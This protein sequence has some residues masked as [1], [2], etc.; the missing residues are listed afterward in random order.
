[1][2][3]R[4][5]TRILT[6]LVAVAQ[7]TSVTDPTLAAG[8]A[9]ASKSSKS[10]KTKSSKQTNASE[11]T[12]ENCKKA[13]VYSAKF[14]GVTLLVIQNGKVIYQK[15][16]NG[17]SADKAYEL[18]SGTK[19][20]SG[21]AALAAKED[22][23]IDLDEKISDT[24][25]EWKNRNDRKDI[26]VRQL[27]NLVSGVET[28]VLSVP[29]YAESINS[30]VSATPGTLFQYGPA[31]FQIFGEFMNRKLKGK[32]I[33]QYLTSRVLDPAGI[34]ISTWRKGKD[35]QVL[36]P[37]GAQLTA[38]NWARLGELVLNGGTIDGKKIL[39]ASDIEILFKGTT[40]NPMY[41]L[42]W[43]LNRPIAADL[44]KSIKQLTM[45]SDLQ[46]GVAGVPND[47]VMAAGAGKQRLYVIPSQRIVVVRQASNI[48]KAL[49]NHDQTGFSDI[50]FMQLLMRGKADEKYL[51]A[52]QKTYLQ[53]DAEGNKTRKEEFLKVFDQDKNGNIDKNERKAVREM[54][55]ERWK[56]RRKQSQ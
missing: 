5:T 19:S 4:N 7:L 27:L 23:I 37:Q 49:L 32:T 16:S 11:L 46:Y 8:K 39:D 10:Q 56:N 43:W 52:A 3:K 47:L 9:E 54:I 42:T 21:I 35:G 55:L 24:I 48:M 25:T 28:K 2:L 17:A 45:A 31:P 53:S 1:M 20:F 29:T 14:N 34:K 6:F 38:A 12:L 22:G 15:Y 30:N 13:A 50:A 18:A 36:L 44:R 41:G 33:E 26:T 40:A 51:N